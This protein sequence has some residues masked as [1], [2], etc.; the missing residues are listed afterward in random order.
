MLCRVIASVARQSLFYN[1]NGIPTSRRSAFPRNDSAR[2]A[3]DIVIFY[4]AL[5]FAD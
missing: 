2:R 1:H 5:L 3:A 4:K